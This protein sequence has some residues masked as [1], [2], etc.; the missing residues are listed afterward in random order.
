MSSLARTYGPIERGDCEHP[1]PCDTEA[2]GCVPDAG[3]IAGKTLCPFH[4]ALW[5][6][7]RGDR[8]T[9]R[10]LGLDDEIATDRF[11]AL[12]EAPPELQQQVRYQRL[13][14]DHRGLAH[15]YIPGR[16]DDENER[17][18]TI[19]REFELVDGYDVPPHVGLE[20]WIEH[21][22]ERRGWVELDDALRTQ[23]GVDP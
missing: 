3:S 20:G 5:A 18:I 17:V 10:Q 21:V 23:G 22:H 9:L 13:G 2:A 11:L 15:Y 12:E 16:E 8:E 6:D 4:L 14:V 7:T 1:S 19:D